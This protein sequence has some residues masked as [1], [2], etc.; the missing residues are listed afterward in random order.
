MPT[1][2]PDVTKPFA[3]FLE[4]YIYRVRYPPITP[5]KL[6][7]ELGVNPQTVLNWVSGRAMPKTD[8][9]QLLAQKT[10]I[11]FSLLFRVVYNSSLPQAPTG[12][13]SR[14]M[15]RD[16]E[17][18]A[19]Q[20][21]AEKERGGDVLQRPPQERAI[22]ENR[23]VYEIPHRPTT[24]SEWLEWMRS[25]SDEEWQAIFARQDAFMDRVERTLAE[26]EP[27]AEPE[28]PKERRTTEPP[29]KTLA[30]VR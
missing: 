14:E 12:Q 4:Y 30:G 28:P 9:M 2:G 21:L 22:A 29:K 18:H 5:N 1:P 6:A 13:L 20:F 16:L 11:P 25:V 3:R 26:P 7:I 24:R 8:M 23:A 19:E 15:I 10:G 27:E 17:R